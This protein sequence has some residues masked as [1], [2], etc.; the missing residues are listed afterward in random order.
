MNAPFFVPCPDGELPSRGDFDVVYLGI[1]GSDERYEQFFG[2][3]DVVRR[4]SLS[5]GVPAGDRALNDLFHCVLDIYFYA[6]VSGC[7]FRCPKHLPKQPCFT[8]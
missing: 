6:K 4:R 8:E 3:F 5:G 7:T 1:V 2:C